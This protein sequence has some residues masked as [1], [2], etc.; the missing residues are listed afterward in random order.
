MQAF[1]NTKRRLA[2]KKKERNTQDTQS[3]MPFEV[4][5]I[6]DLRTLRPR[7]SYLPPSSAFTQY[8]EQQDLSDLD[9]ESVKL[10]DSSDDQT[11]NNTVHM[12]TLQDSA[13]QGALPTDEPD[14]QEQQDQQAA[15]MT[16]ATQKNEEPPIQPR[17]STRER[18]KK[19]YE[20][21]YYY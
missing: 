18:K 16:Q 13:L 14:V 6:P 15:D 8:R 5:E 9:E 21:Y 20:D 2:H 12:R 1:A 11:G 19:E 10:H 17:R 3:G 7:H 4:P